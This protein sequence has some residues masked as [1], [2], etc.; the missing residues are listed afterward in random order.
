NAGYAEQFKGKGV[1]WKVAVP[2]DGVYAQ[3]YSQAVNKEAPHPAAA[4]L[5]MEFLYSA[6]GQNLYLK[7]H[8]RA[9]LL[10]VLTQDG[11]VDKDA[12]AKLPQIQGTP[13][14]PASAELD[15]AKATLAEKWDK[16]LS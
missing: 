16:A 9:V 2:T 10:P 1:D 13:A 7:G 8:A 11:T 14:F 5:W 15:K 12:A 6:E 3:Y 4:R